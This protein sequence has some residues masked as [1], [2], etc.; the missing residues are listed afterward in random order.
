MESTDEAT[1]QRIRKGSC[2]QTD[3]RAIQLLRRNG[4]LSMAAYVPDFQDA[5]HRDY[6]RALRQILAYDPDQIQLMYATPH[7]WTTYY[8][9]LQHRRVIQ[10]DLSR[11]DYKHQV[12]EST[13][14]SPWQTIFWMKLIE[15]AAQIRPRSIRRL[16]AHPDQGLR[17]AMRWYYRIGRKVWLY[18]WRQFLFSDRRTARGPT[19]L[20]FM[21]APQAAKPH[22]LASPD[23]ILKRGDRLTLA[24]REG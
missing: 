12:M 23:T 11:W 1:L 14:L 16:L 15:F 21:G 19:L 4:I 9:E 6:W 8:R 24:P 10:T 20:R 18:E 17:A 13:Q 22:P 5:G 3:R 7:R 2:G